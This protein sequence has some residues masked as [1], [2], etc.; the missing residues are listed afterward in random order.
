MR[1][2]A[3]EQSK[4]VEESPLRLVELL[5]PEPRPGETPIHVRARGVY[6]THLYIFRAALPA[7]HRVARR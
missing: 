1:A 3:L 6:H 4:P 5:T 7:A 2:L